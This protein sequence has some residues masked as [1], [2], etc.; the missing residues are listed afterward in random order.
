MPTRR[1]SL[2]VE[3]MHCAAC[4]EAVT[5]ALQSISGVQKVSVNFATERAL[6]EVDDCADFREIARAVED[7]GY[8]LVAHREFF[9]LDKDLTDADKQV[10]LSLPGVLQV[11][12][13]DLLMPISICYLDGVISH[14]EL[15]ERLRALGYDAHILETVPKK[16][17]TDEAQVA[18]TRALVGLALSFVIMALTMLPATMH[19]DWARW[20][21]FV[22]ATFVVVW[23]GT[24]FFRRAWNAALHRT[25]NMDTLVSIGALSAYGYSLWVLSTGH[26]GL[27]TEQHLYFDSASFIL[28][29]ISLGKGLEAR[30]IAIATA[31]LRKLVT[32]LP[33]EA[34]V[35]RDGKEMQVQLEAVRIG[36]IVLVRTGERVAV[37]GIVLSGKAS[38]DESLLTGES[39]PVVKREGDEVLGGSLCIDGFLRMEALR[40]GEA[41]FV[42]QV[43]RLMNEAQ[44]TRPQMQRLA[45]RVAGVFVPI[46]LGLGVATFVSWLLFSGDVTK[47]IITAVAVTVIACPCAMGL[48]TPTAIAVALGRLAHKGILVRNAEAMEKATDITAVVLD[49]TGTVTEG[50]MCVV[51]IWSP[52]MSENELLQLAASAELGSLHPIAKAIMREAMERS[53]SLLEP[54]EVRTEVGVGI[55]AKLQGW[56]TETW[57]HGDAGKWRDGVEV[58][59]GKAN[60]DELPDD[61]P[62][63]EWM[64][65]GWS[66][67][68]VWVNGELQGCI[69]FADRLRADA[70]D[71]VQQLKAIGVKVFLATGDK[72]EVAWR[73]AQALGCDGTLA[74][75]TSQRKAKFVRD[76][77]ER[78]YRV[79]MIGDGINDAVALSQADIGVAVASGT[80]LAAKAADVLLVTD[81]LT[82]LPHFLRFTHQTKRIMK[83][84][85]FWAFAYNMVVLPLAVAGKLNPMIAAAAM[86]FSSITVV[87]NA[88]RLRRS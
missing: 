63:A 50:Q 28:S 10:L 43:A 16:K 60:E 35:V 18:W 88:L 9:G 55:A 39:E 13:I 62:V 17:P 47:A 82:A 5:K 41:S 4:A 40:V 75:A 67:S 22:L 57:G 24:P 77:Q 20:T 80:E 76:L 70:L 85:L 72:D 1:Y 46:V 25:A 42:A 7:A 32:L 15:Q 2:T 8:R 44:S 3:G 69:A 36:E 58:F 74:Q 64:A 83:Q 56:D 65:N 68:G 61:A 38:T 81:K 23:V 86:A 49:K 78:D 71:A 29:V 66:V 33:S 48:A 59:V 27:G 14:L 37:D 51:A 79:L 45:D 87:G 11:E 26:L 6:V 31:S 53:I 84:N 54:I 12:T 73:V 34:I 30:A 21:E 19:Q 52:T